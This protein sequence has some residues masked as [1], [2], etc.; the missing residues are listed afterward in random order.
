MLHRLRS[1]E[2]A[3]LGLFRF[4]TFCFFIPFVVT[5]CHAKSYLF[6]LFSSVFY[7]KIPLE[8]RYCGAQQASSQHPLRGQI[9]LAAYQVE[10]QV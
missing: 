10:K 6:L 9:Y 1:R 4:Y 3:L 8:S 7:F 5:P 2:F